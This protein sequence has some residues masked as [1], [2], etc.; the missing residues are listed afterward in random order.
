[1]VET[2][3][4]ATIL[5]VA[6]LPDVPEQLPGASTLADLGYNDLMC[7]DLAEEL[8]RYVKA[9]KPRSVIYATDLSTGMTV[10]DCIALVKE[11]IR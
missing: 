9:H 6:L 2:D 4:K 11:K 10:S 7:D 1:M 5:K 3:I 8:D